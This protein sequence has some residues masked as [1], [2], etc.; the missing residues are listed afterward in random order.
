MR[1]GW[2]LDAIGNKFCR[3]RHRCRR[4]PPPPIQH[5]GDRCQNFVWRIPLF[6]YTVY[7]Q[8][9]IS[10]IV[11]GYVNHNTIIAL[12]TVI[13]GYLVTRLLA[14]RLLAT[15]G[16]CIEYDYWPFTVIALNTVIALDTTI[17]LHDYRTFAHA[18]PEDVARTLV[19]RFT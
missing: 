6:C 8:Y 7:I 9:F 14:I 10:I 11:R 15:H 1:G 19:E 4:Q 17:A 3:C 5:S 2:G 12:N 18:L 13:Y 16:Y